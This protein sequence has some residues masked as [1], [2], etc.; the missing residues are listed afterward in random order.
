MKTIKITSVAAIAGILL[1]L[2]V[3]PSC[4]GAT[5]TEKCLENVKRVF[6]KSKIYKDP[7]KTYTFYVVD[8]IG[9]RRVTTLNLSNANIDEITE[10]VQI[11]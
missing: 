1:L 2:A 10:F 5:D 4:N 8:S 3:F 7:S 9:I 6:P 11:K